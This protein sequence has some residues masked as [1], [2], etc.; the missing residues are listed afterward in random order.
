[1][2]KTLK[3]Y[4]KDGTFAEFNKYT[5]DTNGV[6][7]NKKGESMAYNKNKDGYNKCG[8]YD[9]GKQRN[10]YVARAIASTFLGPPPTLAHT[11]DHKNRNRNDDTMIN[12][13]WANQLEQHV[14]QDRPETRKTA[15]II[16]KNEV[17]KTCNEWIEHLKGEKNQYNHEYTVAMITKYAQNKQFG[18]AY[19]EYPDL[20][21]EI[22]KEIEDSGNAQGRWKISNMNRVKYITK[23]AENVMSGD[24][25]GLMSGYPFIHFTGNNWL[26]HILSFMTFFPEEYANKK[27]DEIVLHEEDDPLDFRPHKLRLGT[28]SENGKDAHYNGKYDGTKTERVRCASYINGVLEQEHESQVDAV[29]YLISKGHLNADKS[30]IGK[31]LSGERKTA[32]GRVWKCVN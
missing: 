21:D 4:S 31:V 17:E 22:W 8:V 19:K 11:A 27:N 24:R 14:N 13:R 9:S 18:F 1:M 5:I 10:I 12:I 26:C 20:D 15:F 29:L 25:L 2:F 32:C 28:R 7:K 30:N 23:Y 6:I 3:Y 16:I